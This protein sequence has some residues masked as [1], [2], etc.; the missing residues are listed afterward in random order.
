VSEHHDAL[1]R[2]NL[3]D[4]PPTGPSS[5]LIAVAGLESGTLAQELIHWQSRQPGYSPMW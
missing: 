1:W 5:M 3:L 2:I 4:E